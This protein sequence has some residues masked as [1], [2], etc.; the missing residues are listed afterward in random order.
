MNLRLIPFG[1]FLTWLA[2]GESVHAD[3]WTLPKHDFSL[4]VSGLGARGR[5][6][7]NDDTDRTLFLNDGVS[8]VAGVALNGSVGVF[9]GF[10]IGVQIPVLFYKLK[11]NF[12]LEEGNSLG[13]IRATAKLSLTQGRVSTA[14]EGGGEV[15]HSHT[16]RPQSR[17]GW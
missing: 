16:D 15:P 6:Y 7:F 10:A 13:D 17:P 12:V 4:S 11:D 14:V 9:D 5:R 3:P 1:I 8:R 2:I